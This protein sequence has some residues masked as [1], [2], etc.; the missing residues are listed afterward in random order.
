MDEDVVRARLAGRRLGRV[1]WV[2]ETG[3]T[4]A[5]L[6]ALASDPSEPE[7]V[8]VADHQGAGRGRL[9]RR[10]VA[11]PGSGLLVSALLR[12]PLGSAELGLITPALA[13]AAVE[14]VAAVGVEASVKWPND[15]VVEGTAAPGKLAGVL[16]EAVSEK[17]QVSAVV[18]GIGMN[19]SWPT[20]PDE[21]APNATSVRWVSGRIPDRGSL[22]VSLLDGF[23]RRL[24]NLDVV[25]EEW[26]SRCSTLGR[27]VRVELAGEKFLTG[28]AVGLADDG[29]LVV[30]D[31]AGDHRVTAGDVVHV[32]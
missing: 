26:R 18:A 5:D 15:V 16:A 22:L 28:E 24:S 11:P 32:R 19:V 17:G 10:W 2:A 23:E 20:E 7:Q 31:T 8:L 14:A 6:A 1:R 25:I 13:L 4:N 21:A 30:R 29:A 9:D 3:S 12:A 27:Q